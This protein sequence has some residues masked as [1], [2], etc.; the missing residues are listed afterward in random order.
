MTGLSA[1]QTTRGPTDPQ[2]EC[3]TLS[4]IDELW[5]V[6]VAPAFRPYLEALFN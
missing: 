2:P 3:V 5:V 4:A 6:K 1:D